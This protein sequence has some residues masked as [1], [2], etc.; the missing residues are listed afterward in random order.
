[1]D[2]LHPR[3]GSLLRRKQQQW[4]QESSDS[5][6][7]FGGGT[8]NRKFK[9]RSPPQSS[10]ET[11][12][13]ASPN[14]DHP[15]HIASQPSIS[16][17]R[18]SQ[19][20]NEVTDRNVGHS[21][22]ESIPCA[23]YVFAST[24]SM[25]NHTQTS[26]QTQHP[27]YPYV[28]GIAADHGVVPL[29]FIYPASYA[30][31][32]PVH[33]DVVQGEV[34][35]S[36]SAFPGYP[37]AVPFIPQIVPQATPN[38]SVRH[39]LDNCLPTSPSYTEQWANQLSYWS[40]PARNTN[41]R[42]SNEKPSFLPPISNVQPLAVVKPIGLHVPSSP[43]HT[44][45]DDT[46]FHPNTNEDVDQNSVLASTTSV[47]SCRRSFD[48]D[49]RSRICLGQVL[50]D[51]IAEKDRRKT[52]EIERDRNV[53]IWVAEERK[54]S[55]ENE[56]I[57]REEEQM[58]KAKEEEDREKR[59]RAVLDSI[60]RARKESE[61][62][63]KAKL[64]K[65]V[66]EDSEKAEELKKNVLGVGDN[67]KGII[68]MELESVERQKKHDLELISKRPPVA[69]KKSV[70]STPVSSVRTRSSSLCENVRPL[71]RSYNVEE[72]VI[73]GSSPFSRIYAGYRS[74]RVSTSSENN[75]S[76]CRSS[77]SE[78]FKTNKREDESS[79]HRHPS[80]KCEIPVRPQRRIPPPVP[81]R[82]RLLFPD[83]SPGAPP[84]STNHVSSRGVY[85]RSNSWNP[86][87]LPLLE[88]S[89]RLL[90]TEQIDLEG[91]TSRLRRSSL[92]DPPKSLPNHKAQDKTT[93][94]LS[95]VNGLDT[96]AN[97]NETEGMST[98]ISISSNVDRSSSCGTIHP[99]VSRSTKIS[100]S[101]SSNKSPINAF[102]PVN[103]VNKKTS[104]S[105]DILGL[106]PFFEPL[107]TRALAARN[108][109]INL[110]VNDTSG[111]SSPESPSPS[112][113]AEDHN[114]QSS[115]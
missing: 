17:L 56:R 78:K 60:E 35:R 79:H 89:I 45:I 11:D 74:L 68:M 14:S 113:S 15:V 99:N 20:V 23:P 110:R 96:V 106:N 67:E 94:F 5:W 18:P 21:Q 46:S 13:T 82:P 59:E 30:Q 72:L 70:T 48:G 33:L 66:L 50:H 37:C 114:W 86:S 8:G 16:R 4:A 102:L 26:S 73:S 69:P 31:P 97:I 75:T 57:I 58:R 90:K 84:D 54:N 3:D 53:E 77:S 91:V 92:G 25:T 85:S 47:D 95:A 2:E 36:F 38:K 24:S 64:Y 41:D 107:K 104:N 83:C 80:L 81:R 42:P 27:P 44:T 55:E 7:P 88:H 105:T 6:F 28:T 93:S 108:R 100:S 101:S 29:H 98:V 1:M 40:T 111:S 76:L 12:V 63:R 62:L 115:A 10:E 103:G 49:D 71:N 51:Q 87:H 109:L 65:H 34:P 61:R 39:Q 112:N 9:A 52:I 32:V 22:S 19:T 43:S